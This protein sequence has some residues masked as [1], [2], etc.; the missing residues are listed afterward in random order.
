M[1]SSTGEPHE[2]RVLRD[3]SQYR[4]LS[5]RPRV[6]S[7]MVPIDEASGNNKNSSVLRKRSTPRASYAPES[8]RKRP[9]QATSREENKAEQ[10]S[11]DGRHNTVE[12]VH[13]YYP[14]EVFHSPCFYRLFGQS[15][16]NTFLS[17]IVRLPSMDLMEPRPVISSVPSTQYSLRPA[18]AWPR[19]P[20]FYNRSWTATT[21]ADKHVQSVAIAGYRK[22][23]IPSWI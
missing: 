9:T 4:H 11:K 15:R 1:A 10:Q 8:L 13:I 18:S 23:P 7:I 21:P 22:C 2:E 19:S 12:G 17:L 6:M 20:V 5:H 16:Y 14:L 3:N